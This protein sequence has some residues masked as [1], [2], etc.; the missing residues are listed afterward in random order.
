MDA[1]RRRR[2]LGLAL[3]ILGGMV[4]QNL[5]NVV[6]TAMVGFLGN[7][8]LAAVGLGGFVVFMC[9]ALILG[10]STGV[11]TLAA[12][13]KGEGR[14]DRATRVLNT[15][16]LL[17][18]VVAPVFSLVLIQLAEPL[19]HFLNK[20]SAVIEQGVPY[21]ELRLAAIVFVGMNFAFRGYWNALDLSRLYMTTL[22]LMHACNIFLNYVLI[23]GHF[24]APALG[25]AGAGLASAISMAVGTVIY[26]YLGFTHSR[27]DGF[28]RGAGHPP[29]NRLS[30]QDIRPIRS[31]AAVLCRRLRRYFLDHRNNRHGRAGCS[32][33]PDHRNLVCYPAG[34]RSRPLL[35]HP[36]G[37]GPRPPR[38]GRCVLLGLGCGQSDYGRHDGARATD[39]VSTGPRIVNFYSRCSDTGTRTLADASGGAIDA[40]RGS[41]FC[42]HA[43]AAGCRRRQRRHVRQCRYS[44]AAVFAFGL[45]GRPGSGIRPAG[46][47]APARWHPI[48]A[49]GDVS[50]QV[51]EPAMAAHHRLVV[52]S[53]AHLAFMRHQ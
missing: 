52:P 38:P 3:P 51:E 46:C 2:I 25:V 45:P 44:V 49:V 20:D 24:G 12:R 4:S 26:F 19:F 40:H 6:D 23:F 7:P 1:S 5:L 17:V 9:Q 18:L 48:Y 34:T 15:A 22:I 33:R 30:Y 53:L 8:A 16:L 14:I 42:F 11:Q 39:V 41:W 36:R 47:L 31:A 13:K 50:S 37:P 29:G 43:R 32:K 35:C 27:K 28:M 21:V 10:I